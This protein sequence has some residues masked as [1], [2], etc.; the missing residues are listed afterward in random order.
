MEQEFTQTGGVRYGRSF[1]FAWNFT[2]P[3]AHLRVTRD[4]LVL[5]VS[6]FGIWRRT[7][8]FPRPAIRQ[9]RW[10]R[11]VFSL[12]LQIEH[13]VDTYPPFVLFWVGSRKALAEGLRGFGY[14]ISDHVA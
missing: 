8:S 9:L 13:T 1:W 6:A 12:G 14:E 7:F 3:F 4:A 2:I 5:S 11:G 10:K